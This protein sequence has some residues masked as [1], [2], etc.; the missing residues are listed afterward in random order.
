[1]LSK[2]NGDA[3]LTWRCEEKGAE[4]VLGLSRLNWIEMKISLSWD[5][6]FG[7]IVY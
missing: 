4:W 2:F 6:F 7:C 1:M 3:V 5:Q